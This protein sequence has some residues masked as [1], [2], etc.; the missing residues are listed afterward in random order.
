MEKRDIETELESL[1]RKLELFEFKLQNL[2]F[3]FDRILFLE[4]YRLHK[5]YGLIN[6]RV[7]NINISILS[8]ILYTF[9]NFRRLLLTKFNFYI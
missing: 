6:N 7:D 3:T 5:S 1:N 9:K 8:R 4:S 2:Y